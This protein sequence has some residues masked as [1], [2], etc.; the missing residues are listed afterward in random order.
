MSILLDQAS[1]EADQ[2]P[3]ASPISGLEIELLWSLQEATAYWHQLENKAAQ[4]AYSSSAWVIPW[5]EKIAPSEG[6]VRGLFLIGRLDGQPAFL[7]PIALHHTW[8]Q[9]V[10]C[11][12]GECYNNQNT[13]T[14]SSALIGT[15][16]SINL[17]PRIEAAL[18][19]AGVDIICLRN[20]PE[21]LDGRPF[22]LW[23][24]HMARSTNPIFPF[25]LERDFQRF[26]AARRSKAARKKL[27]AK[28]RK[29]EASG[30]LAIG[31]EQTAQGH[32]EAVQATIDQRW[33]RQ[34]K[35]GVPT[36]FRSS[37]HE[38]Y[39]HEVFALE[40]RDNHRRAYEPVVHTLRLDGEIIATVLGLI[41]GGR[42]YCYCTSI[43]M[44]AHLAL[45]PGDHLMHAVIEDMCNRGL[46][47]FDMGLGEER[48]KK[49]WAE[50]VYL[51]DW[52]TPLT[53][54]GALI[55]SYWD[56]K[57]AVKRHLRKSPGF[58]RTYKK[59]RGFFRRM[60]L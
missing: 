40:C 17:L 20:M 59:M 32:Q 3:D 1:D 22:P 54:G 16:R 56:L 5:L 9:T 45:S 31:A 33:V 39:L 13:G 37:C 48:F 12:M 28:R 2:A 11:W 7:L 58:W 52:I 60:G 47:V 14:W 25:K 8:G 43:R 55:A 49:A 6:A 4:S 42:Y 29:L 30:T 24:Q 53:P 18:R 38:R 26:Y 41:L 10:A 46:Q 51:C 19:A 15:D 21:E 27:T 34:K 36:A 23:R 50:P 35:T 44:D 57:L